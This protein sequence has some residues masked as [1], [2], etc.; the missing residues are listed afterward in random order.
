MKYTAA[1]LALAAAVSAQDIS[2]FPECSLDCIISGIGSGTSCELTDFAC[3]CE[4]TQSLIT[5]AT[6][7]VLEACGADVALSTPP[8]PIPIPPP[9]LTFSPRRGPPRSRRVLRRRWRWRR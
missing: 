5:S 8:S 2:I 9:L 3:V 4:N 7:C 1:L 6:P